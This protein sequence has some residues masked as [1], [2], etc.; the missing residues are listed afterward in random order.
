MTSP[1]VPA[2]LAPASPVEEDA[3]RCAVCPHPPAAHDAIG[4]RF[5]SATAAGAFDRGCVCRT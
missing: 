5:C 1:T 2:P 3:A 4:A